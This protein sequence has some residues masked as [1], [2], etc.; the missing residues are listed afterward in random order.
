MEKKEKNEVEN[1]Q[2]LTLE[3]SVQLRIEI[4]TIEEKF[5][6]L[7]SNKN[8]EIEGYKKQIEYLLNQTNRNTDSKFEQNND[9]LMDFLNNNKVNKYVDKVAHYAQNGYRM[10][11]DIPED[12]ISYFVVNDLIKNTGAGIFSMTDKGKVFMKEY[13][14]KNMQ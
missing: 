13:L 7:L 9:D 4:Q 3:Q 10:S 14:K 12:V 8:N 6:K 1:K 2:L 11:Q 5:E